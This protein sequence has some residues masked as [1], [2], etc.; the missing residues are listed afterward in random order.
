MHHGQILVARR[1]VARRRLAL[2]CTRKERTKSPTKRLVDMGSSC[3]NA[4]AVLCTGAIGAAGAVI[5]SSMRRVCSSLIL[6]RNASMFFFS[7]LFSTNKRRVER[8]FDRDTDALGFVSSTG[9]SLGAPASS[10]ESEPPNVKSALS[11]AVRAVE[12]ADCADRRGQG[13]RAGLLRRT[14][15]SYV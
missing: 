9:S 1:S 2:G 6:D 3:S 4:N 8:N 13:R 5:P 7:F 14:R 10:S 11:I 12:F 15:V